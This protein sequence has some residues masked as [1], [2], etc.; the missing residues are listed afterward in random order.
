MFVKKM[1]NIFDG[2][3]LIF[4]FH[5]FFCKLVFANTPETESF[6]IYFSKLVLYSGS[7]PTIVASNP[8]NS[9]KWFDD[10]P[11]ILITEKNE[12]G[13]AN[14]TTGYTFS[15]RDQSIH[16]SHLGNTAKY[17][18]LGFFCSWVD[19]SLISN[20]DTNDSIIY[21]IQL[22]QLFARKKFNNNPIEFSPL[23]GINFINYDL[24]ISN[25]KSKVG[26]K[27]L[28]PMPFIG[29][30]FKVLPSEML[31]IIYDVHFSKLNFKNTSME[32]V[33]TELEVRYKPSK[34]FQFGIGINNLFLNFKH[35]SDTITSN[36]KIPLD[37]KF[38]KLLFLY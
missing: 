23:I 26:N 19:Y 15:L 13:I 35:S 29:Y 1:K 38:V 32:F 17:T 20:L 9:I 34:Y 7:T 21:N 14:N 3:L 25:S 2:L 27:S 4:F 33:D 16:G 6:Q 30:N 36:I 28:F 8:T 10:F 22:T 11:S 18:C 31:E 24:I 12:L 37:S 5:L